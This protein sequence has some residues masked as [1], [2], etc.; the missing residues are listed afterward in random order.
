MIKK[1][2]ASILTLLSIFAFN[3]ASML[4]NETA[5]KPE[6]KVEKKTEID[7]NKPMNQPGRTHKRNPN[8]DGKGPHQNGRGPRGTTLGPKKDCP[9]N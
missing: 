2:V 8:R 9:K 5:A 1:T 6:I 7:Y 3:D 4:N